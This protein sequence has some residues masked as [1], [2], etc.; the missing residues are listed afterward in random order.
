ML[1][2]ESYP[3]HALENWDMVEKHPWVLGDFVWTA[4]DY[5]GETGIGHT[6]PDKQTTF[7][8]PWPW[9]NAYCGDIDLIGGKKP[10]SWYRDVV[11]RKTKMAVLVHA[12]VA[13]GHKEA[14]SGWGWPDEYP[15][16]NFK[17]QEDKPLQVN[18]YSRGFDKIVLT[19][20]GKTIDQENVG[21][22]ITT[23]FIVKYQAGVLKAIG[24][25]QGKRADSV[26][27]R[28]TGKPYQIRL[29]TDRKKIK[30]NINDLCYV[31]VEVLDATGNVI[32][33]ADIPVHFTVSG[34]GKIKATGNANPKDM[35]SF[36][37]PVRSTFRGRCLVIIQPTGK[38][39][40]SVLVARAEGLKDGK[41]TITIN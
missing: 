31:T 10:Q 2:T 14:V 13:E 37:Q 34:N 12:P 39:G 36:E 25:N 15:S 16:W 7:A 28:T 11:W 4:M 5:M 30:A 38:A 23:T 18:V 8:M 35:A 3:I 6:E 41:A 17:G 29:V 9:F 20:N 21:K 26:T 40:N 19:L 32:P 22:G 33:D 27:L 1:G 24:L